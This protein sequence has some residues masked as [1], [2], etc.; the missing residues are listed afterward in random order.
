MSHRISRHR[1]F[2]DIAA[3]VAKRSTC[4][5]LNVGAVL[6]HDGRPV[7]IGYN[8]S[9]AGD[10]HCNEN[11]CPGMRP[12]GCPTIHAEVNAINHLPLEFKAEHRALDLY[13]TDSP[14]MYC[15]EAVLGCPVSSLPDIRRV[16]F[17]TAYRDTSPLDFLTNAGVEVYRLMPAGYCFDWKHHRYIN[18]P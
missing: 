7:S 9:P 6:V 4:A 10:P 1:M 8:G 15:A 18:E 5:R 2:M 12:G 17:G 14:C 16:F 13:V 11:G 3:V